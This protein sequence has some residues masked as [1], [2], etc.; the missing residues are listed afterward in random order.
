MATEKIG[1]TKLFTENTY[2]ICV[3]STPEQEDGLSRMDS[4][5]PFGYVN[6][7]TGNFSPTNLHEL[8]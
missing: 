2:G 1:V 3:V 5:R 7:V 4:V 6:T 8:F